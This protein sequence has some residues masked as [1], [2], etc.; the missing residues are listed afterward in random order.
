M[1]RKERKG[2]RERKEGR[3]GKRKRKED[4]REIKESNFKWKN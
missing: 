2:E 1:W 4:R 3:N